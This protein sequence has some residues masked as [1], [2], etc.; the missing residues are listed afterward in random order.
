MIKMRG[1]TAVV[2]GAGGGIGRALAAA[3]AREGMNVVLSG[4]TLSTLE[5]TADLVRSAGTRSTAIVCDVSD[6]DAVQSLADRAF[7]EY[8][9]VTLLCNNAAVTT[10]G[11][12][13]EHR[14]ADWDWVYG[15][16]L[17]GVV[18]G[19]QAFYPRMVAQ[20]GGHIM[21]T[22]SQAGLV[23]DWLLNHGPY[24]SAKCGVMGLCV[25]LRPEAAEHNV[26]VSLLIPGATRTELS[27]VG[28]PRPERFSTDPMPNFEVME[29]SGVVQLDWNY[30]DPEQ[31]A[32]I[33]VA[34]IKANEAFIVTHKGMKPLVQE[35]FDRILAAYD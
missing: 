16:V 10:F 25:A 35:Y 13:L 1:G 7:D 14:D 2:T 23:P 5:E 30:V 20:G 22:H 15:V 21:S 3:L 18:H 8:G 9:Q 31:V 19:V 24:T 17:M 12:L 28:R 6:R 11:P 34:G 33:A 32:D 29:R 26:E 4:T 27:N